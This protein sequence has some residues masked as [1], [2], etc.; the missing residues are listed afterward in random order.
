MALTLSVKIDG[1]KD[2]RA[3]F[4]RVSK[5]GQTPRRSLGRVALWITREAGRIL[6]GGA[7]AW[8]PAS[9]KLAASITRRIDDVSVVVGSNLRY[10]AVQHQ[11]TAGLPGGVIRPSKKYLAI[12]A[13]A[14]LRRGGVWP[15]DIAR[16]AMRFVP[17]AN[18]RI[19]TRSW[20]GPA[21]V[22][23]GSGARTVKVRQHGKRG[24]EV[25]EHTRKIGS[26]PTVM[27]ALIKQSRFKGKL[28]LRLPWERGGRAFLLGELR[29]Q[30][31]EAI[32][33]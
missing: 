19:G 8:G 20:I 23:A 9:G 29:K 25:R 31:Q 22:K 18:I 3:A 24:G 26:K 28:Y 7:S 11:G 2:V 15:R 27:F 33:R 17:N 14:A 12:P 1:E 4:E 5:I 10:A 30:Y 13:T 16:D 21:L 6:R 32:G